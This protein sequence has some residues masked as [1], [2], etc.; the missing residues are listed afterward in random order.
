MIKTICS[1]V[2]FPTLCITVAAAQNRAELLTE[3]QNKYESS[4]AAFQNGGE[5]QLEMDS[6]SGKLRSVAKSLLL[7]AA[8]FRLAAAKNSDE[9]M[10]IMRSVIAVT[11]KADKIVFAPPEDAGS[12]EPMLRNV[13]TAALIMREIQILLQSDESA[14]RWQ[15]IAGATGIVG[16]NEV[17]FENGTAIF[18]NRDNIELQAEFSPQHTFSGNGRDFAIITVDRPCSMSPDYL[19]LYLCEFKDGNIVSW[20]ELAPGFLRR[21]TLDGDTLVIEVAPVNQGQD[22]VQKLELSEL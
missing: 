13:E 16:I 6:D 2:L 1:I 3:L 5:S 4:I 15:R 10:M 22:A 8:D 19:K 9:R 11:R 14:A 12:A 17:Q 20:R 18:S 21:M 7:E